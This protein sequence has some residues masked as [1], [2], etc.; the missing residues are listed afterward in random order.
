[1]RNIAGP[2][3]FG[4]NFRF[5]KRELKTVVMNLADGNSIL[6]LGIRRTGKSSLMRESKRVMD[7]KKGYICVELDCQAF[8]KPSDLFSK[9][10]Q[11]LP[12]PFWEKFKKHVEKLK[13]IPQG[14]VKSLGVKS[15][16]GF[17]VEASFEEEIQDYWR[18]ISTGIAKIIKESDE[19]IV[20]FLDELPFFI[21]NLSDQIES[22]PIIIEI[23]STLKEWRNAGLAMMICGSISFEH[24]FEDLNL[25]R[26]YLAGCIT[27]EIKP[28]S[29]KEAESL[30]DELAREYE[31]GWWSESIRTLIL[32]KVQDRIPYFL[33]YVI[34]QIKAEENLT[35]D[36]LDKLFDEDIIRI[37]HKDFTY[38]FNERL[39]SYAEEERI[40]AE[41]I[42]D[43]IARHQSLSFK[44]LQSNNSEIKSERVLILLLKD[45]VL[46]VSPDQKYSFS[47]E[48][49]KS[50]WI[51]K[52]A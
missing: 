1:M 51:K 37:L 35:I 50:W 3:V 12:K 28:F 15:L 16:K 6:V 13:S 11:Y 48:F 38:Q 41:L 24:L 45:D 39:Q 49:V 14:L 23:F 20:L 46:Q 2:P 9:V 26:K 25:S 43:Q 34:S 17:G 47:L 32:E 36:E 21:H 31:L 44:E 40:Q 7:N 42:L 18:P 30:L 8:D 33:Q 22:K 19:Q 52:R 10:F 5:R 4:D 29:Q 27:T